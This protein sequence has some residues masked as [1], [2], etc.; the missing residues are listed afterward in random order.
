MGWFT[1]RKTMALGGV[2][3]LGLLA[4]AC[5]STSTSTASPAASSSGTTATTSGTSGYSTS[6]TSASSGTSGAAAS[7]AGAAAVKLTSVPKVGKVLV[8]SSGF[9][10]YAFSK[11]SNHESNCT[12]ACAAAWP[13]LLTSATPTGSS[14]VSSTLLGTVKDSDGKT[15][16]T[17]NGWPLYTFSGDTKAGEANGQGVVAFGGKWAAVTS[18]GTPVGATTASSSAGSGGGW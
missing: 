6:G 7:S 10:L 9:T 14:G 12:G 16:V 15:Q 5:G 1:K 4:S 8:D 11:D 2:L 18:A 3:A 17:Y 13:P